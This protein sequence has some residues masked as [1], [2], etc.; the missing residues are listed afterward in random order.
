MTTAEAIR[1]QLPAIQSRYPQTFAIKRPDVDS[2]WAE[3]LI[4]VPSVMLP[5]GWNATICTLLFL[6]PAGFPSTN[7]RWF[8]VDLPDLRLEDGSQPYYARRDSYRPPC[9]QFG[10]K[11]SESY[12]I[13]GFVA[14]R[15]LTKFFWSVQAWSPKSTLYTYLKVCQQRLQILKA[16]EG[17]T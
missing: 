17:M 8:W 1:E 2:D 14:W 5:K 10:E 4:V 7:P 13:P 3:Q 16:Y 6:A 15:D 9:E 12:P 11:W